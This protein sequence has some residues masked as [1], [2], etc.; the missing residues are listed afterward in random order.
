MNSRLIFKFYGQEIS[1][2]L[3]IVSQGVLIND[4]QHVKSNFGLASHFRLERSPTKQW[5]KRGTLML[6]LPPNNVI[7]VFSGKKIQQAR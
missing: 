6:A 1:S 3:C 7:E 5:L 2:H 4:G